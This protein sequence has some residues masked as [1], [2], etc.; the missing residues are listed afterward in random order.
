MK[1]TNIRPWLCAFGAI[2]S[3]VAAVL[4]GSMMAV[5]GAMVAASTP[6][7]GT[8]TTT[9]ADAA[10][11][12][13]LKRNYSKELSKVRPDDAPLDTFLRNIGSGEKV[14]TWE[15]PFF[16]VTTR[17]MEDT[18]QSEV[19]TATGVV[20]VVVSDVHKFAVDDVL[21]VPG[22]LAQPLGR[23]LVLQVVDR[24]ISSNT[25]KCIAVNGVVS[26]NYTV[27][28]KIAAE[29]KVYCIGNAKDEIQAQ[30]TPYQMLPGTVTNY[31]QIQMQQVEE[32]TYQALIAKEID[33]GMLEYKA[34]SLYDLRLK[35]ELTALYGT[36]AYRLDPITNQMKH[37]MGGL[38]EY[39]GKTLTYSRASTEAELLTANKFVD[40]GEEIFSDVNG[41]SSRIMIVSPTLMSSLMKVPTVQKQVEAGNTTIK[42][43][44]KFNVID[45]AFG[46]F[47]LKMSKAL[48]LVGDTYGGWVIDPAKIRKRY[49]EE[50]KWRK[51]DLL[52]SG[53][54]KANAMVLE[55]TASLEVR[56]ANCHARIVASA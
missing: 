34:D 23:T 40:W 14:T 1:Q 29:S 35:C 45:T 12:E 54:K 44:L 6:V 50:L 16:E 4:V 26:G 51:V 2:F 49:M 13:L 33:Y 5:A 41:S 43:G 52:T 37:F 53:Q 9:A 11:P 27:V 8:V 36:K 42:Y 48:P 7:V 17:G 24:T 20:E 39:V 21:L 30:T 28:P 19:S 55:E 32:G 31:C 56:N 15:I 18:V 10:S 38:Q 25:L 3:V 22:V 46:E 47:L